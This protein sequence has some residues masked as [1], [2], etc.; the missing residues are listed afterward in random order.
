MTNTS[1]TNTKYGQ[2]INSRDAYRLEMAA[3][4]AGVPIAGPQI[5]TDGSSSLSWFHG[6]FVR[7]TITTHHGQHYA[8]VT[9][10]LV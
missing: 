9:N 2:P 3:R 5:Y 6:A 1:T 8:K 10:E 7:Y 4:A